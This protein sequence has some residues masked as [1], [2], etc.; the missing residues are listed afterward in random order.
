MFSSEYSRN[1]IALYSLWVAEDVIEGN[2]HYP[3]HQ[4]NVNNPMEAYKQARK[5]RAQLQCHTLLLWM[6]YNNKIT[7]T[8]S[9][10]SL[11]HLLKRGK[12]F[13]ISDR[14]RY[15]TYLICIQL[16]NNSKGKIMDYN[17][18]KFWSCVKLIVC[19]LSK[20]HEQVLHL[21]S[22]I[23]CWQCPEQTGY[24]PGNLRA[25]YHSAH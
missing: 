4:A 13:R 8:R 20:E 18:L 10:F 23:I 1:L 22:P 9:C 17:T 5:S 6:W 11:Y 14:T 2:K 3:P 19:V 25:K 12:I 21:K 7:P 15:P 16:S 24:C